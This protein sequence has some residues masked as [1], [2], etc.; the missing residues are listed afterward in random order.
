MV[1]FIRNLIGNDLWATFIMSLVPLIELKGAI[2]FA[3]GIGY[4][5]FKAMALSFV[6]S[7]FVFI[8]IYFLLRPILNLMKKVKW[9]NKLALKVE[10][11]FDDKAKETMEK[12]ENGSGK[13]TSETLL[14]QIGVFIFVAI[15]LPMTGVW[16]GTAIAVFLNLKFKDVILPIALGN[17]V[18]GL[19]ISLLAQLCL[20][21]WSI[22]TLDYILYALFALAVVLLAV[23]IFKIMSKKTDQ[24]DK[25]EE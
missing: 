8:P 24:D 25:K 12:R 22:E 1:E 20:T 21:F 2:V 14:K 19:I 16:T 4:S 17:L 3:R 23:T 15:P 18:A 11:Y 6:G 5:F 7:T 9:F 13:I 10:G